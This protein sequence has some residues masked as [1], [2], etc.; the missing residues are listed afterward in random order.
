MTRDELRRKLDENGVHPD[1]YDFAKT[2]KD[3]VYCLE[4]HPPGWIFYYREG[5]IRRDERTFASEHDACT[6]F[7]DAVLKDPRTRQV[8]RSP[9]AGEPRLAM[10]CRRLCVASKRSV[11]SAG[12]SR[13][14]FQSGPGQAQRARVPAERTACFRTRSGCPPERPSASG[15]GRGAAASAAPSPRSGGSSRG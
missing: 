10:R 3:E 13:R 2:Q 6:F 9:Q 8:I 4:E 7:L 14:V 5:R 11:L 1:V 12:Q 15:C